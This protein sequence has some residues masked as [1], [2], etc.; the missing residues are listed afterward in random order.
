[1]TRANSSPAVA[2]LTATLL[3]SAAAPD[4]SSQ[5]APVPVQVATVHTADMPFTLQGIGSVQAFNTVTVRAQVGGV[6][7]QI[8]FTE[9]QSVRAGEVLAQIDPRPFQAALD[10][11]TAKKAQDEAQL[12][13]ARLDLQRYAGLG[14]F[15]S[16]QQLATQQAMVAQLEAQLRGDQAA[17]ESAQ[18]QLSYTTITSPMDGITG[19]RLVDQ[20]N[21]LRATDATGIV[22]I[23]QVQPI[24]VVF[25]LPA[26]TLAEIRQSMAAGP[27][28]VTVLERQDQQPLGEGTLALLD[29]TIDQA[30]GTLRL[31]AKLPNQNGALWPG[32]FVNAQL[33]LRVERRVP[34]VPS[35]AIQ[36]GPDGSWVYVAQP[37]HTVTV[38]PVKV[39]RYGGGIAVLEGGPEPGTM[40]VTTGQYR[41]APGAHIEVAQAAPP[42]QSGGMQ[43]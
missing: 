11:A 21:L 39:R 38:Q 22:V 14:T 36:R 40:V 27:L 15:A 4:A 24:S 7:Q 6:L 3:L 13:N 34:T 17:I 29:N 16:H 2:V 42:T 26:E 23:T 37:D 33:L 35:T 8:R 19:I 10:Q 43:R 18:T 9:G 41:L 30:T 28:H 31:K 1:M 25:T 20:G 32:Q 5:P 12:Q